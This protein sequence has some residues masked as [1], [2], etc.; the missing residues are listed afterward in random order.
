LEIYLKSWLKKLS[1]EHKTQKCLLISWLIELIMYKLNNLD[2]DRL[3]AE[4]KSAIE[5]KKKLKEKQ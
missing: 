5:M 3:T 1:S 2:R 4:E